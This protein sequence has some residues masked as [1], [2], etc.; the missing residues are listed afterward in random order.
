M[1]I[2]FQISFLFWDAY[3]VSLENAKR[4]AMV[5]VVVSLFSCSFLV[6]KFYNLS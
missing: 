3:R 6:L 4:F 1:L 2:G 5:A